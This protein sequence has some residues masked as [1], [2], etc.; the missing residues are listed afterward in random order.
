M[1][2]RERDA[3]DAPGTRVGTPG[4]VHACVGMW[5]KKKRRTVKFYRCHGVPRVFWGVR[6]VTKHWGKAPK[7]RA[8][9]REGRGGEGRGVVP[10]AHPLYIRGPTQ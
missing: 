9:E 3:N 5:G 2:G 7:Q 6:L 10:Q 8:G 4:G 1:S